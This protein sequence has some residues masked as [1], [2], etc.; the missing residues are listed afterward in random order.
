[1]NSETHRGSLVELDQIIMRLRF[2]HR[3]KR[4]IEAKV[5]LVDQW[6]WVLSKQIRRTHQC[7]RLLTQAEVT[8]AKTKLNRWTDSKINRITEKN[9]AL[10]C[11]LLIQHCQINFQMMV[12]S[13]KYHLVRITRFKII[14]KTLISNLKK[15]MVYKILTSK[16]K[17]KH[18]R[19]RAR[20]AAWTPL[21][22][23]EHIL[24]KMQM[25]QTA[26]TWMSLHIRRKSSH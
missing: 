18:P 16:R 15:Q 8:E 14:S 2:L 19:T 22:V 6:E 5:I 4:P 25:K 9:Q 11:K 20:S 13:S 1:M 3:L 17:A 10:A 24:S 7:E 26:C 23:M 12:T 21:L